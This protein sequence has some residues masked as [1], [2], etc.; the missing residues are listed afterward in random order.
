MYYSLNSMSDPFYKLK[1]TYDPAVDSMR[2]H[3][4]RGNS[5]VA[6]ESK[7]MNL[8]KSLAEACANLSSYQSDTNFRRV[9]EAA[10]DFVKSMKTYDKALGET[11]KMIEV[12]EA[13]ASTSYKTACQIKRDKAESKLREEECQRRQDE[14]H[15]KYLALRPPR[16]VYE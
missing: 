3:P 14:E 15:R 1:L 16:H 8:N 2:A 10:A 7:L 13:M 4:R 12:R 9:D 11:L 6:A 5:L